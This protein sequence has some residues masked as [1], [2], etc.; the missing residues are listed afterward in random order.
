MRG[1]DKRRGGGGGGVGGGGGE[2][3]SG[4]GEG[5]FL[6]FIRCIERVSCSR[7]KPS[8]FFIRA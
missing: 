6:G 7:H 5:A 8:E 1:E 4:A 2:K 3:R